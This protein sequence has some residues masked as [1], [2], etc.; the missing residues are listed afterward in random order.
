MTL[1]LETGNISVG[2]LTGSSLR[3]PSGMKASYKLFISG[4]RGS[5]V[6]G[7][8]SISAIINYHKFST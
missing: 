6:F 5:L 1:K 3:E 8:V 7:L 2:L 4:Y